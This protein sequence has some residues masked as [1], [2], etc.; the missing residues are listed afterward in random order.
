MKTSEDYVSDMERDSVALVDALD[1]DPVVGRVIRGD[2]TRSAYVGF[3][4]STYHYLRWSG[5]LLAA[6]ARALRARGALP[7][8]AELAAAKAAEEAPHH[9][10]VLA[11]LARCG[12][13]ASRVKQSAAPVAVQAYVTCSLAMAEGGTPAFLGAAYMLERVSLCRAKMAAD[14]LRAHARVPGIQHALS[15]LDGHGEADVEHVARLEATLRRIEEPADQA[16]IRLGGSV[17]T[18][19]YPQFFRASKRAAVFAGDGATSRGR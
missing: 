11:D 18:A 7:W 9:R 10:W 14:N 19:L 12:V 3:L 2:V 15:F 5:R 8:L 17:L 6:T 16:A 4:G 13:D 1:R